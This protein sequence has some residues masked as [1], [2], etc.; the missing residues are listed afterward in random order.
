MR[1]LPPLVHEEAERLR[2]NAL[3]TAQRLRREAIRDFD[4]SRPVRQAL[5]RLRRKETSRWEERA[6]PR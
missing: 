6:C 4:W 1:D 2:A 5:A 3:A